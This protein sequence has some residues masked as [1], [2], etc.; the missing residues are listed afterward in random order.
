[1]SVLKLGEAVNQ[2]ATRVQQEKN[3][4]KNLL[5]PQKIEQKF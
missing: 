3:A 4:H 5:A 2:N 1:V